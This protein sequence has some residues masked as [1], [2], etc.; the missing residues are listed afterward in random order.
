MKVPNAGRAIVD[1][2]KLR[3]Y[4][5]SGTHN[6]GKHKA[7]VFAAV[8]GLS[9]NDA[10]WLREALLKAAREENCTLGKRTSFGQRYIVDFI[11]T[12]GREHGA[13]AQRLDHSRW[14]GSASPRE[15]L[16]V[17]KPLMEQEPIK[18]LD[19]VALLAN[20]PEQNLITGHVGTVVEVLAPDAFE[21]EFLDPNGKTFAL[22]ELKRN[23]LL[24]LKHEPVAA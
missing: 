20:K 11:V 2:A 12:R 21:V 8:L 19:V 22:A 3:N 7:R 13:V 10:E 24:R 15:L 17:M 5:L 14:R 16:C 4:S 9:E 1:I 18:L 6:E 23:E